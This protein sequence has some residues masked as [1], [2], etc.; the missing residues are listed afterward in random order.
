YLGD[1]DATTDAL[2]FASLRQLHE[3]VRRLGAMPL[4]ALQRLA[5][6]IAEVLRIDAATDRGVLEVGG[7]R[8]AWGARTYVMGILNVTPDSFSAD[9]LAQPGS[10][11]VAAALAQAQLFAAEG[12]DLL[13]VG[14]ESTRPGA[15]PIGVD[16]E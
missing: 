7:A 10:D 13:D 9:G 14:G 1:R 12:A 6:E 2:I 11:A 5:A 3:L 4:P 15:R 16:E 8:F